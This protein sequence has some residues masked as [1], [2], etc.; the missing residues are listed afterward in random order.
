METT[1]NNIIPIRQL[2]QVEPLD[3]SMSMTY[4][5][6]GVSPKELEDVGITVCVD[7]KYPRYCKDSEVIKTNE[8]LY[9]NI[10]DHKDLF[11]FVSTMGMKGIE[12]LKT[13]PYSRNAIWVKIKDRKSMGENRLIVTRG[14][15]P[16][17]YEAYYI[18]KDYDEFWDVVKRLTDMYNNP[19]EEHEPITL[20]KNN[21][22][23]GS[24]Y[25][26]WEITVK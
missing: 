16:D 10:Q 5:Q 18:A 3:L 23:C 6:L 9:N 20:M 14:M 13:W 17:R 21:G 15:A 11:M 26:K 19:D 4:M 2:F 12:D 7:V 22:I 8:E 25:R 1:N 24:G